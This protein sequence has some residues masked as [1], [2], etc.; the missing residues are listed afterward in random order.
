MKFKLLFLS[1]LASVSVFTYGAW[2][3]NVPQT[4]T[5]PDGTVLQIFASGDEFHNWLHDANSYTIVQDQETGYYVYAQLVNDNLLPTQL[6]AGKDSPESGGLQPGLNISRAKYLEFRSR[7]FNIPGL[8]TA[9][10]GSNIGTLNNIVIFIRFQYQ[11]EY[12]E[13]FSYYNSS[14]NGT[15]MVSMN[16]YFDDVSNDQIE[17]NTGFFP[18]PNQNTIVS[19]QDAQPRGYYMP[20]SVSNP[21]GYNGDSQ[22]TTREHTLLK[23]AVN[24]V[25]SQIEATGKDFDMNNDGEV[26]NVCFVIQGQTA[27]WSDLLWPHMWALYSEN[28]YIGTSRV[29]TFNFQ[30]SEA[31]G[32]S[33]LCHEMFHS[34]GAP[35][36]YHY[37]DK[38]IDPVGTWDL[39]NWNRNPP[40]HMTV[41]MKQ[42]YGGWI[43]SIPEI[44]TSGT[45]TLEPLSQN[46]FAAYKIPSPNS[47]SEFFVVEYRKAEGQFES[48]L[49]GSGLIIYR[50]NP[51]I[52]GNADGPPDELY[53]YRPGGTSSVD[54][55]LDNAYFSADVNRT[56]FDD[57]T[58]PSCFLSN[59]A[60]GGIEIKNIATA[61]N[62]ISFDLV[63]DDGF[64][65][66]KNLTASVSSSN[67]GLSWQKPNT[68]NGTLSAYK[69]FRNN[70]LI[71][72]ISNPN[73][74]NFNDSGLSQGQYSYHLTAV[75]QSPSGESGASNQVSVTVGSS[76]QA[77]LI[78][79]DALVS[80][81][82]A[83]PGGT[84]DIYCHLLND[85]QSVS[86]ETV[87]GLY[88]SKDQTLDN[89]DVAFAS[90]AMGELNPGY[91]FEITASD[92][93]LPDDIEGGA[94]YMLFI[95]DD[96]YDEAESNENNNV[97]AFAITITG[98]AFNPPKGLGAG[99]VSQ[100]VNLQWLTPDE[101]SATLSG[102]K[103]YRDNNLIATI[104]D[105]AILTYTDNGLSVGTYNYYVTATYTSPNGESEA[106]NT[107]E[108]TV[109]SNA[110]PDLTITNPIIIPTVFNSGDEI[111]IGCYYLNAGDA[112]APASIL[113]VYIS[114]DLQLDENDQLFATGDFDAL[115]AGYYFE[116]AGEG[117]ALPDNLSSGT[118]YVLY[119]ADAEYAVDESSETNN[120]AVVEVFVLGSEMNPPRNLSA[121]A[122]NQDIT[123]NWTEPLETQA[124]LSGYKVYRN[125][126]LIA[127]LG[128]TVATYTD[129]NLSAGQYSYQIT[130]TY[131]DPVG[132]SDPSNTVEVTIEE[133]KGPDLTITNPMA[134][135]LTL[136]PGEQ[137]DAECK[138]VNIGGSVTGESW[139]RLF[140][141]AD[142]NLD[143]S[144]VEIASGYMEALEPGYYISITGT[145][146]DI[147]SDLASGIYQLLFVADADSDIA[148]SNE[149]NNIGMVEL[150]I[151]SLD[152]NEPNN[153]E[154]SLNGQT[155]NLI[156]KSPNETAAVLSGYKLYRNGNY[157]RTLGVNELN[158]SDSNLGYGT[159][160]YYVTAL[161]SDPQG[162]SSRSNDVTITLSENAKPDL[163]II[164]P[165][166]N[167]GT[168]DPGTDVYIECQ[169]K[170][171]GNAEAGSSMLKL[172]LSRNQAYDNNDIS[173][174]YGGMDPI[175][176]GEIVYVEGEDL[177]IP[178][179]TDPGIWYVLFIADVNAEVT[180][181][182]ENNNMAVYKI[183]ISSQKA[184]LLITEIITL[185]G[186]VNPGGQMRTTMTITNAGLSVTNICEAY[187]YFSDDNVWDSND[188]YLEKVTIKRLFIN[189]KFNI[190]KYVTIPDNASTGSKF[191]IVMID[192]NHNVDETN[193]DNNYFAVEFTI[194]TSGIEDY[195]FVNHLCLY[196]NPAKDRINLEFE[197][198]GSKELLLEIINPLGQI[199]I[200]KELPPS[201]EHTLSF[202][203]K[204]WT[205]G[206]YLLKINSKEGQIVKRIILN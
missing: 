32:V 192:G 132:E 41:H 36:L 97:T 52:E 138:L 107:I 26:D 191:L 57:S 122:N 149:N 168:V 130:A 29:Y 9:Q 158:Y 156:W 189:E 100:N 153:L 37:D 125:S 38:V 187:Y 5:Q 94:W 49:P 69:I 35:D 11:S 139:I 109:T 103:V 144:D 167:P 18:S 126:Q 119:V 16:K 181:S 95:A 22:R 99:V 166:V 102:F 113:G 163:T 3:T 86:G 89:S 152:L 185:P 105:A 184:D 117:I 186:V 177:V 204:A 33:V 30:L 66:P 179:T 45:Y 199:L 84:V 206:I 205:R 178:T 128:S 40:Q 23:N 116:V 106:S 68:G 197:S 10:P 70:T 85:G 79:T 135:P 172:Y 159:Y 65:P 74:L 111:D 51:S 58:N 77:D 160:T 73:T 53:V 67:I 27:G 48:S 14:F 115:Q 7:K 201:H 4:L 155:I 131:T 42:K 25:K 183:E 180:E 143:G 203:V 120:I 39:M 151:G 43:N 164:E 154:A 56:R 1:I 142:K 161:Y 87:L 157:Y 193:E 133:I 60:A 80:P 196:P 171:I 75:Y 112:D 61:G 21:S 124:T 76:G 121:S 114:R 101:S 162:E 47:S 174:A 202:D 147:P 176:A 134:S 129:T 24:H 15:N 182:D 140:I 93:T 173:L 175:E 91:Y 150:M 146:L 72:T 63:A 137:I 13:E 34:L 169:L 123:V 90:G 88:L 170:N 8:K 2:L 54:G 92:L 28:V 190:D 64:Q 110:L 141:S 96:E 20:Y 98:D 50:V 148:E 71:Q 188:T 83:A 17:I 198:S 6:I 81:D 59:G 12:Q 200:R 194:S 136:S 82:E 55:N 195:G 44:S 46:P 108:A 104:Q 78:V 165:L 19:Y 127:S 62:T 118:Y 145:D 31:F